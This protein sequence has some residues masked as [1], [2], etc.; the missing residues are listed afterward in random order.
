MEPTSIWVVICLPFPTLE[1][2]YFD[3]QHSTSTIKCCS[4]AIEFYNEPGNDPTV[5]TSYILGLIRL[6]RFQSFSHKGVK[7]KEPVTVFL[8]HM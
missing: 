1:I 2:I 4:R 8:I 6:R 3:P 5:K 7:P